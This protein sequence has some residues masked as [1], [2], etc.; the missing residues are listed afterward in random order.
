MN[1]F[2][3]YSIIIITV[4]C[5]APVLFHHYKAHGQCGLVLDLFPSN[6]DLLISNCIQCSWMCRVSLVVQSK[7]SRSGSDIISLSG[8]SA[9]QSSELQ[10]QAHRATA[11][12]LGGDTIQTSA[13]TQRL[14][15]Y[16]LVQFY[17]KIKAQIILHLNPFSINFLNYFY[18]LFI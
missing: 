14:R 3:V 16:T 7:H 8:Y 4:L 11:D 12:K 17:L 6:S 1:V 10:T 2:E 5:Y 15:H 18:Y 13:P 9:G